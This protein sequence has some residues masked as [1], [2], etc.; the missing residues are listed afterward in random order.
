MATNNTLAGD[1]FM[2]P[3]LYQD[4]FAKYLAGWAALHGYDIRDQIPE[5]V[6]RELADA[7][8]EQIKREYFL[9]VYTH[10]EYKGKVLRALDSMRRG[11]QNA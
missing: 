11:K 5:K 9:S 1:A 8:C 4:R 7:V 6:L 2:T 3:Q 10:Y